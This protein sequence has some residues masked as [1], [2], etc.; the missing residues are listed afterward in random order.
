MST[1]Q[2]SSYGIAYGSG[3]FVAVAG[4]FGTTGFNSDGAIATS[5]DGVNW[6]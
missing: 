5:A 6:V 1:L 4:A 2:G 3:L